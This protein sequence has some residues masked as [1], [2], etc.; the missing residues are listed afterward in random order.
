MATSKQRREAARRRLQ[1]QLER[2]AEEARKRR[3]NLLVGVAAFAVVIVVG[4]VVWFTGAFDDEPAAEAG[5]EPEA[6]ACSYAPADPATNPNL[7]DAGIPPEPDGGTDPVVLDV[8]ST[9]GP[10]QMTLD[11]TT[12]PCATNS[13]AYLAAQGF[14]DGTPCHR[15]VNSETFGVL[16]CGDPTGTGS[17]GPTYSYTAEPDSLAALA[18]S[19]DG[20]GVIYPRGSIAMAQGGQP[21]TIGSQFFICFQDTQLPPEYTLVGTI[22]SGIEVIEAVATAGNDGSFETGPDGSPGPGGGA[23]LLPITLTTVT[24]ATPTA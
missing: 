22:T 7:R 12:A 3:R 20:T 18:P 21:P 5:D 6:V 9:Q 19:P 13:M 23:P 2:R 10:F 16:Q 15:L 8:V 14:F 24:V 17:G 4:G 11:P 1:R